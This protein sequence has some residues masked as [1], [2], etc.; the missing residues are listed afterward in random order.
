MPGLLYRRKAGTIGGLPPVKD[1]PLFWNLVRPATELAQ[2]V[3]NVRQLNGVMLR[4]IWTVLRG[5]GA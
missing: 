1:D 3:A 4:T 5:T 2:I